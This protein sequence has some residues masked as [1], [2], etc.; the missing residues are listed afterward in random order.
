[1][2]L[3]EPLAARALLHNCT[4]GPVVLHGH[5]RL[6][7]SRRSGAAAPRSSLLMGRAHRPPSFDRK[8]PRSGSRISRTVTVRARKR[9]KGLSSARHAHT[10]A[11]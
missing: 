10:N 7:G 11:P 5:L 3:R 2:G 4:T 9:R 6:G 1:V 8:R